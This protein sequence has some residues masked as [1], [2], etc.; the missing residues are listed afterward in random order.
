VGGEAGSGRK[1]VTG[2]EARN[3]TLYDCFPGTCI[4]FGLMCCQSKKEQ[5]AKH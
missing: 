4:Q 5:T 1:E 3:A 2:T